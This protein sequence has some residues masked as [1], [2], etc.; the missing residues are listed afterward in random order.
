[1]K[2]NGKQNVLEWAIDFTN[3]IVKSAIPDE[4]GKKYGV[5]AF[6]LFM[7]IFVSN[8]LGLIFQVNVGG[9]TLHQE[10]LLLLRR[11]L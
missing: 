5:L 9:S 2:P 3:G 1:M 8:Q 10:T 11:Q 7:F 4:E 6:T